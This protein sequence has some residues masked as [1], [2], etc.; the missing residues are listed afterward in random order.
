MGI[1]LKK[2]VR[3]GD[4]KQA[5]LELIAA[6]C[7]SN[8]PVAIVLKEGVFVLLDQQTRYPKVLAGLAEW[9]GRTS[10]VALLQDTILGVVEP[11]RGLLVW[12]WSTF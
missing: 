10:I 4:I 5:V 1:E 12:V 9:E 11:T 8:F 3:E 6:N 7:L 2:E